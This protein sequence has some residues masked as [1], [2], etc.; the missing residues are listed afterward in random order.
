[1]TTTVGHKD[2]RDRGAERCLLCG[3]AVLISLF[4][5]L[6]VPQ[7]ARS[8]YAYFC[9]AGTYLQPNQYCSDNVYDNQS[10]ITYTDQGYWGGAQYIAVFGVRPDGSWCC[11]VNGLGNVGTYPSGSYVRA[12]CWNRDNL[13]GYANVPLAGYCYRSS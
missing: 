4:V 1:M 11:Q 8:G 9:A 10:V 13:G 5:A 6:A 3:V 2:T 7:A 12:F